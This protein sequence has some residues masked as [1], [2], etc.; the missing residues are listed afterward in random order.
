M[1]VLT[2]AIAVTNGK[3][4]VCK[5]TLAANLAVGAAMAG[6]KVLVVDLDP[7]GNLVGDLG[8]DGDNGDSLR[9]A[10]MLPDPAQLEIINAREGVDVIAGGLAMSETWLLVS[11]RARE[12]DTA[13]E[14]I[15]DVLAQIADNYDLIVFDTP[16]AAGHV[17]VDVALATAAHVVVPTRPD[18]ASIDGLALTAKA[19]AAART[20]N[21]ALRV[22]GV[23]VY[24][25]GA[26]DKAMRRKVYNELET[27]LGGNVEVFDPPI[28]DARKAAIDQRDAGIVAA[29]YE[30]AAATAPPSQWWKRRR[31]ELQS[32]PTY[33]TAA[34][35][36]AGDYQTVIR[37]ILTAFTATGA[38]SAEDVA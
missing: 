28:R 19:C 2:N 3:G 15:G 17:A 29:E 1:T 14:C 8:V 33:S 37:Q 13:L 16:P 4:G 18:A 22:L 7:Q 11:A 24:G 35:G 12:S 36:L 21:P 27:L 9:R 32:E 25:L 31:G 10:V 6:W 26:G 20:R 5:T 30:L 38:T 23:V 34:A